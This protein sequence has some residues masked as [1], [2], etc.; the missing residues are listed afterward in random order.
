MTV[1]G[2]DA[3]LVKFARRRERF[4]DAT[5]AAV[6]RRR[7]ARQPEQANPAL[8]SQPVVPP[9]P[10]LFRRRRRAHSLCCCSNLHTA[11]LRRVLGKARGSDA[12]S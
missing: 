9:V 3:D 6:A 2:E 5:V 4:H 10:R 8:A 11:V 12:D 7:V 1:H